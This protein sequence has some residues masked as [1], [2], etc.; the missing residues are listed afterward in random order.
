MQGHHPP[1]RGAAEGARRAAPRRRARRAAR[2]V[3]A[4][5]V[6]HELRAG[7]GAGARR[8]QHGALG[9]Q[10]GGAHGPHEA[11]GAQGGR[12]PATQRVIV[13]LIYIFK[14]SSQT[15]IESMS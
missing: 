1:V 9:Q 7:G 8:P 12:L 3:R 11:P 5:D 15:V 14:L 13:N 2:D 6:A 10:R 4:A